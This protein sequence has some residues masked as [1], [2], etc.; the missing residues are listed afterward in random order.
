MPLPVSVIRRDNE[1]VLNAT[2][3][4]GLM[5]TTHLHCPIYQ[6]DNPVDFKPLKPNGNYMYHQVSQ[7]R[8]L[9]A[10]HRCVNVVLITSTTN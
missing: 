1:T 7:S 2:E 10:A 8:G 5:T 9:H 4:D 3:R 6:S